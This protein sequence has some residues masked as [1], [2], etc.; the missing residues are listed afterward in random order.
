VVLGEERRAAADQAQVT[1]DGDVEAHGL[2]LA[3]GRPAHVLGVD[4][5]ARSALAR[6]QRHRLHV[7]RLAGALEDAAKGLLALEIRAGQ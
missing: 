2:L 6:L 5:L 3:L 7:E 1:A 4:P